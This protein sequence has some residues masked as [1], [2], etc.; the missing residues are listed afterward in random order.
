VAR[1]GAAD[2]GH[3]AAATWLARALT[4]NINDRDLVNAAHEQARRHP[5]PDPA[6]FDQNWVRHAGRPVPAW[7]TVDPA[8][9]S[10]A[11]A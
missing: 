11:Q 4:I 3:P 8:L 5:G 2:A 6:A 7:F 9:L 1:A 10:S